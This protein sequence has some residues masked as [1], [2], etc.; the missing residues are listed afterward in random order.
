MS[1][2]LSFFNAAAKDKA[3]KVD[4]EA[5]NKLKKQLVEVGFAPDEVNFMV[6]EHIKNKKKSYAEL[7]SAEIMEIKEALSEQLEIAHKCINLIK[8][9]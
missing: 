3:S 9:K 4:L 2:I 6:K 5:I 8:E 7:N 1:F